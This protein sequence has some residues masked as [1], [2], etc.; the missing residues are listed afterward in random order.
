MLALFLRIRLLS[1][2]P[3]GDVFQSLAR[4]R[5]LF[6]RTRYLFDPILRI[7]LSSIEDALLAVNDVVRK[8]RTGRRQT[9]SVRCRS[10]IVKPA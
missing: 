5:M 2:C 6:V 4:T 8:E 1:H 3:N 7:P 9:D 10:V